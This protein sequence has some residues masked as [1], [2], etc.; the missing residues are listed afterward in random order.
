MA[1]GVYSEAQRNGQQFACTV[2]HGHK[3]RE[4]L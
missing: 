1:A 3:V 4:T 2:E